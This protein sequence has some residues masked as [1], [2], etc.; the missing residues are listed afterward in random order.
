MSLYD[1][2]NPFDFKIDLEWFEAVIR[3]PKALLHF[4]SKQ[5]PAFRKLFTEYET[6]INAAKVFEPMPARFRALQMTFHNNGEVAPPTNRSKVPRPMV[7]RYNIDLKCWTRDGKIDFSTKGK[8]QVNWQARAYLWPRADAMRYVSHVR[9]QNSVGSATVEKME[10]LV[11]FFGNDP[12]LYLSVPVYRRP[13]IAGGGLN[14]FDQ[15]FIVAKVEN[16]VP[17]AVWVVHPEAGMVVQTV[18]Y[19]NAFSAL[20]STGEDFTV[21]RERIVG[22]GS[23]DPMFTHQARIDLTP[24]SDFADWATVIYRDV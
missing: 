21:L 16:H 19:P 20:Q 3:N 14:W 1:P 23:P 8:G 2:Q 24:N 9:D 6:A 12:D 11:S 7:T 18:D 10:G 13:K 15:T 22:S 5:G 17:V 4:N